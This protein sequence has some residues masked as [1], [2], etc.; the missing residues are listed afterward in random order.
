MYMDMP[1][2]MLIIGHHLWTAPNQA[3]SYECNIF[4]NLYIKF[5]SHTNESLG[6]SGGRVWG[7]M[8]MLEKAVGSNPA[9]G[10]ILEIFF[11]NWI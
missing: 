7:T 2:F 4:I 3:F 9:L 6:G 10:K 8:S 1:K 5:S 11:Y